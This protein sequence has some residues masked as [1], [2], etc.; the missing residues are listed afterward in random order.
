[1][2]STSPTAG[3]LEI[4]SLRIALAP[5]RRVGPRLAV[6]TGLVFFLLLGSPPLLGLLAFTLAAALLLG[7]FPRAY[8]SSV[9]IEREL[10]VMFVTVHVARHDWK[11]FEAIETDIEEQTPTELFFLLGFDTLVWGWVVNHL[12][13]WLG[14]DF[15]LWLRTP[16][17]ARVLAWQGD[18]ETR[19]RANLGILESQSGLPVTRR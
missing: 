10:L 15:K 19:F 11:N 5:H 6:L 14:G 3:D 16:S 1:M 17:G 4:H 18:G 13:P 8:A 12:L 9:G 2:P 7:S